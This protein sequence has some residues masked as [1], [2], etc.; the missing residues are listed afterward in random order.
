QLH[1]PH[2]FLVALALSDELI[3]PMRKWMRANRRDLE[4]ATR[5]Q[6][7]PTTPQFRYMRSGIIDIAANFRAQLDHR[8]MHLGLDLLLESNFAVFQNFMNMRAQL[9]RLRI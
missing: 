7:G 6:R 5:G 2:N 1:V 4:F 8:L 9:T 3:T